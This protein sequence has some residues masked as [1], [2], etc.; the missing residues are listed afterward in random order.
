MAKIKIKPDAK[1]DA[2]PEPIDQPEPDQPEETPGTT[3]KLDELKIEVV[4]CSTVRPN[5]YNPNWQ[6][7]HEFELLLRSM[8][9]DGFTTPIIVQ[10]DTREIV[11]GEHRWTGAIVHAYLSKNHPLKKGEFWSVKLITEARE[12]RLQ[13]LEDVDPMIPVVL[14]SM[15][16][17]QMRVATLRHNRARGEEDVELAAAV[18][19]DLQ[20]AGKLAWAADELMLDEETIKRLMEDVSAAD[21]LGE[22]EFGEAWDPSDTGDEGDGELGSGTQAEESKTGTRAQSESASRLRRERLEK[23]RA[24]KNEEERKRAIEETKIHR[25]NLVFSND[26]AHVVKTV[27]GDKPAMRLLELCQATYDAMDLDEPDDEEEP[28]ESA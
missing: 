6:D 9:E 23:V 20:E 7:H 1:P 10:K 25:I 24:A 18:L 26:E 12:N 5:T 28:E 19:Q 21:A 15:S 4:P 3:F 22:D 27:L 14:T 17:E 13:I 8:S 16:P 11:D 2:K